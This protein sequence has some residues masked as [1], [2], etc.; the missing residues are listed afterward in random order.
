M[1]YAIKQKSVSI[2]DDFSIY[3]ERGK[4]VY[5]VDGHAF[6]RTLVVYDQTKKEIARIRRKL[7]S[8]APA[9]TVTA[10]RNKLAIIKKSRFSFRTRFIIDVPGPR[11]Y[12][13]VG[14]FIGHEYTITKDKRVVATISKKQ[15]SF[16]DAYGVEISGGD[17]LLVLC[18]A[19]IIDLVLHP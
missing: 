12:D 8:F 19:I 6:G 4:E 7:F 18:C 16:N 17:P 5:F 1:R 2:G 11:D 15:L 10:N 14:N 13:V 9:Y 3:D